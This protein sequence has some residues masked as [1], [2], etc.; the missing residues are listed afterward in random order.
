[1]QNILLGDSL[2]GYWIELDHF[3]EKI[4]YYEEGII[5]PNSMRRIRKKGMPVRG[6]NGHFGDLY[7]VY[8]VKYPNQVL[9]TEQK[10]EIREIFPCLQGERDQ[11]PISIKN[12]DLISPQ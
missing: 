5:Q 3:G 12:S 6:E 9:K 2:V 8:K 7:I 11:K 1:M 10:E 4:Q